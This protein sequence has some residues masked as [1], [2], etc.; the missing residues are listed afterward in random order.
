MEFKVVDYKIY[1]VEH[2]S[3][4]FREVAIVYDY[5]LKNKRWAEDFEGMVDLKFNSYSDQ[6]DNCNYNK[7]L[8]KTVFVG[9]KFDINELYAKCKIKY[10]VLGSRIHYLYKT[11]DVTDE[12]IQSHFEIVKPEK[13]KTY[14]K[15]SNEVKF[16]YDKKNVIIEKIY[17]D[18]Y[19][20][21][22]KL[23]NIGHVYDY[24]SETNINKYN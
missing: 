13:P 21:L 14:P 15:Y 18:G 9:E 8:W 20:W 24:I 23:K 11:N 10:E 22:Y 17:F 3:E 19:D 12:I 4:Y 1:F 2:F 5:A 6:P 7:R 16:N